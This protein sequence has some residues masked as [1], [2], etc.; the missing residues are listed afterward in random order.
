MS[1]CPCPV[2]SVARWRAHTALHRLKGRHRLNCV[3]VKL[4]VM[5][6]LLIGGIK[7]TVIGEEKCKP[8]SD[9]LLA[10]LAHGR[11]RS[12]QTTKRF[13]G[14]LLESVPNLVCAVWDLPNHG[15]RMIDEIANHSWESGF[16][17]HAVQMQAYIDQGSAEAGTILRYLPAF[18]PDLK[19]AARVI[20]G[21]SL[22][23]YIAWKVASDY[24]KLLTAAV[25]IISS[26]DLYSV[27]DLRWKAFE[28]SPAVSD[29]DLNRQRALPALLID[30]FRHEHE[31]S[32]ALQLSPLPIL[33]ICGA[34]D[35]LVPPEFTIK[36][37]QVVTPNHRVEIV[38]GVKHEVPRE[39][40]DL[41]TE[42][43]ISLMTRIE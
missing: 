42:Y 29:H 33:A 30:R 15:E 7:V 9:V 19:I 1:I 36:W 26:P 20:I 32:K 22:G 23:G 6:T 3:L 4:L 13:A 34:D 39:I 17:K 37:G 35:P 8:Q 5:K 18:L 41:T 27:M 11:T 24:T 14:L 31:K 38:P 21:T 12:Q 43:L 16:E 2:T 40:I 10:V 25:P 28:I